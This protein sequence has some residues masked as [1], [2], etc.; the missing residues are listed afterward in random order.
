[1]PRQYEPRRERALGMVGEALPDHETEC[2]A[3]KWIATKF[4]INSEA[5][6]L[7]KRQAEIDTGVR[8]GVTSKENEDIKRLKREHSE[9]RS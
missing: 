9:P 2:A 3:T 1:M 5:N 6:R 8:P 4:G 7:W